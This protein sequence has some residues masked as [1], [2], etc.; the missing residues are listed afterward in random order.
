[1]IRDLVAVNDRLLPTF[2]PLLNPSWLHEKSN[3]YAEPLE[4]GQTGVYLAETCVIKTQTHRRSMPVGPVERVPCSSVSRLG[5]QGERA[6]HNPPD[7][8]NQ[9]SRSHLHSPVSKLGFTSRVDLSGTSA[10]ELP[11]MMSK[12]PGT[13]LQCI[14][15]SSSIR[16]SGVSVKLTVLVSPASRATR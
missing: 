3:F 16:S 1:M 7:E 9:V 15:R 8:S 6:E 11:T 10:E 4:K 5:V 13:T 14:S 12:V 2:Q